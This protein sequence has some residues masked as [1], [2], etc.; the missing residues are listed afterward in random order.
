MIKKSLRFSDA[1]KKYLYNVPQGLSAN[2][3]ANVIVESVSST[4]PKYRY[5][6]GSAKVKIGIKKRRYISDKIFLSQVA[7]RIS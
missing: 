7:K 6:V 3:V 2:S 4:K 5:I 1:Y